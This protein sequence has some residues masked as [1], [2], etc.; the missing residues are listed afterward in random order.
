MLV[1]LVGIVFGVCG[2]ITSGTGAVQA[3]PN[4][5]TEFA[6]IGVNAAVRPSLPSVEEV[7]S[8]RGERQIQDM[9]TA[10]EK[11]QRSGDCRNF[12]RQLLKAG[13]NAASESLWALLFARWSELAPSAMVDFVESEQAHAISG[14][15]EEMAWFAWGASDPHAAT[16]RVR[17]Q[18]QTI[19]Y[20]TIRGIA[21]VD[22]TEAS[23]CALSLPDAQFA[24][25]EAIVY[26]NKH[27]PEHLIALL[28]RSVYNGSRQPIQE[29]LIARL[30]QFDP[31][32]AI[33]EAQRLGR[34]WSDPPAKVFG[35]IARTNASAAVELLTLVPQ[36]RSRAISTV[37][38][39]RNWAQ[40]DQYAA[41]EWVRSLPPGDVKDT[42]LAAVASVI[43]GKEPI[44]GLALIEETGWRVGGQF[45]E[46]ATIRNDGK[47]QSQRQ[48][49]D[50]VDAVAVGKA[51]LR[52][53]SATD[54]EG[55]RLYI[56][57]RAPKA[58]RKNLSSV[59]GI[60]PE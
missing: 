25:R 21:A 59:I 11:L 5:N 39:A 54:L 56:E 36:S 30:T 16:E 22:P 10:V 32:A 14:K 1:G 27:D 13:D 6:R 57:Q 20:A 51:L 53:L 34:I 52:Q 45:Y 35:E 3:N 37:Q 47:I 23:L 48:E 28:S 49:H 50:T 46:V 24:L 12:A 31:A 17:L 60:E 9:L 8:G 55:A 44:E 4:P 58:L 40:T 2:R 18:P 19:R 15:L 41:L 42:S 7:L 43:G 29:A 38:V 33:A 26:S